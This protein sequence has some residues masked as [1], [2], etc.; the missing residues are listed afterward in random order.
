MF[1]NVFGICRCIVTLA[2]LAPL[3][4]A[5]TTANAVLVAGPSINDYADTA[6]V[7]GCTTSSK[8]GTSC[9]ASSNYPEVI[10]SE[11]KYA[12]W[13]MEIGETVIGG[14]ATGTYV[15]VWTNYIGKG[16]SNGGGKIFLGDLLIHQNSN[17]AGW[18]PVDRDGNLA[19]DTSAPAYE[20]DHFKTNGSGHARGSALLSGKIMVF[21]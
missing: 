15:K 17:T 4:L 9:A 2:F 5:A 18:T 11:E 16:N 10:G 20:G 19:P 8:V 14:A 3:V 7:G 21:P 12:I 1:L 6:Y 13:R